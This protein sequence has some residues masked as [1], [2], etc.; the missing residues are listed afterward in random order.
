L[1][2]VGSVHDEMPTLMRA[3][4]ADGARRDCR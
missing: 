1:I 3:I 2:S 4:N